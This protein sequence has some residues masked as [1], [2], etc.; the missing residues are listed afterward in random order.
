MGFAVDAED[1]AVSI[2][3]GDG[4]EKLAFGPLKEADWQDNAQLTCQS[5]E[6]GDQSVAF[7]GL[8]QLQMLGVLFR[9]E[10]RRLKQFLQQDQVCAFARSFA[11]Q[12]LGLGDIRVDVPA[13]FH[14]GDSE[15]QGHFG[16]ST[17]R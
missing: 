16:G 3:N 8:S 4:V 1:G 10:I 9:A 5:G 6:M 15:G 7:E 17:G 14:L 12:S 13:A 11:H 2:G